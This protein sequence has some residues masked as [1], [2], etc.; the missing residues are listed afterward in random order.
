M[1]A[2][3]L[4]ILMIAPGVLAQPGTG[5]TIATEAEGQPGAAANANAAGRTAASLPATTGERVVGDAQSPDSI[6]YGRTRDLVRK[7]GFGDLEIDIL[8]GRIA[9]NLAGVMLIPDLKVK[10]DETDPKSYDDF[11]ELIA[12]SDNRLIAKGKDIHGDPFVRLT[13]REGSSYSTDIHPVNYVFRAHCYLFPNPET[14]ELDRIIFQFYR[15]NY[16][17]SK[18]A[19]EL[20]RLI[21]PNPKDRA[22]AADKQQTAPVEL[23]DNSELTLEFYEAASSVK[24]VWE[25]SDGIPL[26]DLSPEF[27]PIESVYL[28][29]PETPL[30]YEEQ[31]RMMVRYKRLLRAVDRLLYTRLRSH[32]LN[33]EII[34]EQLLDFP[35]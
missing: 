24:P 29:K 20:R 35:S 32:E 31:T 5:P 27:N 6:Q 7:S 30:D 4:V 33:R 21:H 15:V 26:P 18:Y 23:L 14:G 8:H 19:R 1:P 11:W 9:R 2:L 16:T 34:I 3:A 13:L 17:G 12:T 22:Q 25:G 28:N 10:P